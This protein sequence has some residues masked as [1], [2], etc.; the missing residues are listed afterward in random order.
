MDGLDSGDGALTGASQVRNSHYLHGT[1]PHEQ[2]RLARLN[3]L[4]ND[5]SLREMALIRGERVID[6]GCGLGQLSRAMGRQVGLSGTVIGIERSTDQ[7]AEARRLAAQEGEESL[8]EFRQGEAMRMPL[9]DDEWHSFDVAHARYLLEHV[10][11]PVAVVRE[12]VRSVRPGGRIILE[13]DAHD[14]HRL[15]PEPPGFN[16]LWAAYL[17]TYDRV[18]NDPFVGHRL[19]SLLVQAGALPRRN[20]WLFFGACAGQPELLAAY[21]DNLVRVI[22]GVREPILRLGEIEPMA[23]DSCLESIRDWGQR[24]DAAYWYAVSWAEGRRPE[25]E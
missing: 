13:D 20:T 16:R 10:P 19:V 8:M 6:I 1:A 9:R 12:M 7:L 22:D 14:K 3:D 5:L 18:G 2:E 11:D 4:L 15:W 23:F 21:V 24:P 17:R 25:S